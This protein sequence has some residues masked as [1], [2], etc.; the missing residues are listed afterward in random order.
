MSSVLF[1]ALLTCVFTVL[2]HPQHVDLQNQTSSPIVDVGYATYR[3]IRLAEAGVDQYL[4]MRYAAPPLENLRFRGPQDPT[5]TASIQNATNFGPICV[6]V[7]QTASETQTEDCLF[8]NVFKPLNATPASKLPVWVYI[9]GGGYAENSNA[10]YNGTDVIENSG[11]HHNATHLVRN[12]GHSLVF[13]NFNYRVGVLGF[14]ANEK[15]KEDGD[16]NAGLL[17]QRK[18]GGDP[19]HV[20][21]HGA[22]AGG[23]SVAHHLTAY[24]GEDKGLFVGAVPES[25]FWPTQRTVAEMEFQFRR[26][27]H[28]TGCSLA[29]DALHCLRSVD[30]DTIQAANID[31]PFP[32]GSDDP[33]PKWYWLPVMTGPGTL[34]PDRLYDSFL[35][36]KFVKVPLLVGDDTDEGT[37]FAANASTQSQVSQFLK[38]NYPG[39]NET[40][41]DQINSA[42]PLTEPFPEHAA[43]YPS[44]AAA[45]GDSTFT[46]PGNT[47][48]ESM[49]S[50]YDSYKVW[51]YRYNVL[52][53]SILA[54]G[55]GVPHTF[56]TSAIFGPGYAGSASESYYTINAEIVPVIMSYY[57]SFIRSLN[58]NT[59]RYQ[60]SPAW[61]TWG[62]LG[63]GR[64]FRL[65]IQTNDTVME[66]VPQQLADRCSLWRELSRA[67]ET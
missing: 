61:E 4:G 1:L 63:N 44:A 51:D 20:V 56:E 38:N 62:D 43:Y 5:P 14:L 46:C 47:M 26:F 31:L 8:V 54:E 42:Y 11:G 21:I 16:L 59:Y 37:Y 22:S 34:V 15:V 49:S 58:P 27:V 36:R 39:L 55:F 65:K 6:G 45:Y 25:P 60:G 29:E 17:D 12:S 64:G 67:M 13:V 50:F 57:V 48:A 19:S 24:D 28:D 10:N 53:P 23:G 41:L 35:S 40:Q 66:E 52:D 9:Q 32:G 7:G 30:L 33:A 3:G 2:G 18:F